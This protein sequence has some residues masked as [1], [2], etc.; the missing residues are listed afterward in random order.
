MSKDKEKEKK[1]IEIKDENSENEEPEIKEEE[2]SEEP[3]GGSRDPRGNYLPSSSLP[4]S[5]WSPQ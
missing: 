4:D 2:K 5:D 3:R 1:E